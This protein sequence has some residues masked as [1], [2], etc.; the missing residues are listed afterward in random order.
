MNSLSKNREIRRNVSANKNHAYFPNIELEQMHNN[1]M[2]VAFSK[3]L[4]A[5]SIKRGVL[6]QCYV[7][8]VGGI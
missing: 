1:I 6:S 4:N 2:I 5:K 3:R 7:V 8:G